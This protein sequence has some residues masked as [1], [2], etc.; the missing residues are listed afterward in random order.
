MKDSHQ[1]Q[2]DIPVHRKAYSRKACSW[3]WQFF[4]WKQLPEYNIC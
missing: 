2:V 4:G 1:G 3:Y